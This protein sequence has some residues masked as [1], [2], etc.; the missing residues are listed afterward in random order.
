M[1]EQQRLPGQFHPRYRGNQVMGLQSIDMGLVGADP[2]MLGARCKLDVLADQ[3][4]DPPELAAGVI[5]R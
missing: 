5:P 4:Q 1:I 2:I 3:I